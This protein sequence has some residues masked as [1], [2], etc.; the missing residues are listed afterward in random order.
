MLSAVWLIP[1]LPL[2]G[3][4][5]LLAFGRKLGEPWSGILA[6]TMIAGSFAASVVTF[7]GLLDRDGEEKA[8]EPEFNPFLEEATEE[9]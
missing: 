5:L 1:A 6:T 2:L 8:D 3:A 7:L 4:I 9:G